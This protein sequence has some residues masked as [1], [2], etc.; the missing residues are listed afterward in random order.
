MA[1]GSLWRCV[2]KHAERSVNV[3]GL[4][5]WWVLHGAEINRHVFERPF[6]RDMA[7]FA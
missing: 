6:G 5:L 7:R 4:C 2:Q 3:S 1:D